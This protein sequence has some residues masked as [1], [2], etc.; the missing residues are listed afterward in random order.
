MKVGEGSLVAVAGLS[1][2]NIDFANNFQINLD[3]SKDCK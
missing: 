2:Q 1:D 3:Y